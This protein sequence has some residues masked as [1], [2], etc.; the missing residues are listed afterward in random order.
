[1]KSGVT[2]FK[3]GFIFEVRKKSPHDVRKNCISER[4]MRRFF[5][6]FKNKA[7]FEKSHTTYFCDMCYFRKVGLHHTFFKN[8]SIKKII[9][10]APILSSFWPDLLVS[11]FKI[12]KK[13][14]FLLHFG[15][16]LKNKEF[17]PI[18]AQSN[19]TGQKS[20][21][22]LQFCF[23]RPWEWL[24][25]SLNTRR[26]KWDLKK[27]M[28][29]RKNCRHIILNFNN[30]NLRK[31]KRPIFVHFFVVFLIFGGLPWSFGTS[32]IHAWK[33]LAMRINMP[34]SPSF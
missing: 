11:I 28:L 9:G 22:L 18:F 12:F 16:F 2:F 23:Y 17:T 6:K 34:P 25:L 8:T 14:H 29:Q 24:I 3:H 15:T 26:S 13:K 31:A 5:S 21:S 4:L 30:V 19:P 20:M 27:G 1:M 33:A 7:T 10:L 32:V